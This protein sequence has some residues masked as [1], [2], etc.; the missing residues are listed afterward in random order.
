MKLYYDEMFVLANSMFYSLRRKV[1]K[2]FLPPDVRSYKE[3]G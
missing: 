1:K 2:I 3:V